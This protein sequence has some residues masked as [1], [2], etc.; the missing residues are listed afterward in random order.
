MLEYSLTQRLPPG[1]GSLFLSS[2]IP[3]FTFHDCIVGEHP[4]GPRLRRWSHIPKPK[5]LGR[6]KFLGPKKILGEKFPKTFP[7]AP[8]EVLNG[9]GPPST[10]SW[11]RSLFEYFRIPRYSQISQFVSW[12][13]F[14]WI[15][16]NKGTGGPS[17]WRGDLSGVLFCLGQDEADDKVA[18]IKGC[19]E[20]EP[21]NSISM[22]TDWWSATAS[23]NS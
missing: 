20:F 17:Y 12:H 8:G 7:M 15:H 23:R 19:L 21:S 18:R 11:R 13:N 3:N 2:G 6:K 4:K 10:Y 9:M 5:R 14:C 1:L 16:L 22:C